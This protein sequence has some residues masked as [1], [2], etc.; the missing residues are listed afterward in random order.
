MGWKIG[1]VLSA[2]LAVLAALITL[3]TADEYKTGI[4]WVIALIRPSGGSVLLARRE[5]RRQEEGEA[6][7]RATGIYDRSGT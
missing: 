5:G 1:G 7:R 2:L 3:T 4:E 6:R